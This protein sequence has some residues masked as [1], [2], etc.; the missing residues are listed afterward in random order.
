MWDLNPAER[1]ALASS[2]L[3]VG[4]AGVGR[5]ALSPRPAG[6]GW[7]LQD[8][9]VSSA[10]AGSPRDAVSAS[11]ARE[12]RAQTPLAPAERVDVNSAAAEEL[13]RIPGVGPSLASELVRAR[14]FREPADLLEVS[15]IGPATLRRIAPFLSFG[16][17][18]GPASAGPGPGTRAAVLPRLEA[19]PARGR[20][21]GTDGRLDLNRATAGELESLPGIGPAIASRIVTSRR[22]RRGFRTVEELD[23]VRGIGPATLRRLR[24]LV[25][26]ASR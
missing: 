9:A 13:R 11:L 24:P 20:C 17:G 14:P 21:G 25:C 19:A 15:G 12:A 5:V 26:A 18:V 4:L 22:E 3:V 2:L 10:P 16:G 23:G 1:R 8:G 7:E 6:E